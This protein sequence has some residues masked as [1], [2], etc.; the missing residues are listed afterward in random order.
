MTSF[1]PTARGQR[2]RTALVT[3]AAELIGAH[4]IGAV[5]H[6]AVAAAARVPLAATTYYF[7]SL[8]HLV[9][10]GLTARAEADVSAAHAM[11]HAHDARRHSPQAVATTIIEILAGARTPQPERLA[12]ALG[13]QLAAAT[14]PTWRPPTAAWHEGIVVALQD[15]LTR[16]GYPGDAASAGTT[17]A[18]AQGLLLD[19]LS[20][21]GS[22][23][24]VVSGLAAHL[25]ARRETPGRAR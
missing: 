3:A 18:L 5:S 1:S 13:R 2:R 25:K 4:G 11:V 10:A 6:R 15:L 20:T 7:D 22:V 17:L 16:T 19:A 8:E 14:D 23:D 24:R 9:E 12:A 21:T